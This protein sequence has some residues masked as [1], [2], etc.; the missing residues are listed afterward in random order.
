MAH[1]HIRI[2]GS[3]GRHCE[4]GR[5][6]SEWIGQGRGAV[7]L[8]PCRSA[9]SGWKGSHRQG[10]KHVRRGDDTAAETYPRLSL[11]LFWLY[12]PTYCSIPLE[13]GTQPKIAPLSSADLSLFLFFTLFVDDGILIMWKV[14]VVVRVMMLEACTSMRTESLLR[15]CVRGDSQT[16]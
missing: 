6:R 16:L 10:R 5:G 8:S 4:S 7:Y 12:L 2:Q 3:V 1:W 13:I 14:R 11:L 9:G 15:V